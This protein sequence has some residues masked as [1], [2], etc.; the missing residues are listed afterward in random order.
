MSSV[1]DVF[2]EQYRDVIKVVVD[3]IDLW[4]AADEMEKAEEL[5]KVY[6]YLV[7]KAQS[8]SSNG[9]LYHVF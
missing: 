6:D 3:S 9:Q 5:R 7:R 1:Y 4:I 8:A 2:P